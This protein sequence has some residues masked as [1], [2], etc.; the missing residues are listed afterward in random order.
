VGTC[1]NTMCAAHNSPYPVLNWLGD[2][3]I[4]DIMKKS[5]D[6]MCSAC[7]RK[8]RVLTWGTRMCAWRCESTKCLMT[9]ERKYI[10]TDWK[11]S[12]DNFHTFQDNTRTGPANETGGESVAEEQFERIIVY[13]LNYQS[14]H[15]VVP[16]LTRFDVPT[17]IDHGL[18]NDIQR[19]IQ[20]SVRMK[21]VFDLSLYYPDVV[22][23]YATGCRLGCD[24]KGCG[25]GMVYV[26]SLQHKLLN[27]YGIPS[28]S[29]LQLPVGYDWEVFKL[30]IARPGMS[31]LKVFIAVLTKAFYESSACLDEVSLAEEHKIFVIPLVFDYSLPNEDLQWQTPNSATQ[32]GY[33]LK[34]LKANQVLGNQSIPP[35]G[36]FTDDPCKSLEDLVQTIKGKIDVNVID[37][38]DSSEGPQGEEQ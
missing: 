13:I 36:K 38:G 25:P 18:A 22:I 34:K 27:D 19:F 37:G 28:Y 23:S 8:M 29:G 32:D 7:N 24:G 6:A 12:N 2:Y 21:P 31:K 17:S 9:Q 5:N 20:R 26:A 3:G 33:N 16:L 30:R 1:T 14:Y 35:R 11:V 15:R 10:S 4:Y